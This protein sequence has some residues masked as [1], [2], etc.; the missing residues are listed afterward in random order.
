[1]GK[2]LSSV[3]VMMESKDATE[4]KEALQD[5]YT[6]YGEIETCRIL[7]RA[8]LARD[9]GFVEDA[10]LWMGEAE[11]WREEAEERIR[12]RDQNQGQLLTDVVL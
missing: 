3:T 11:C 12:M 8:L 5:L 9:G 1:M 2:T 6:R 7:W 4:R 10:I